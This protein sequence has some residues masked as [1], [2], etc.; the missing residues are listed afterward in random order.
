MYLAIIRK[1]VIDTPADP[2]VDPPVIE[3]SHTELEN[4]YIESASS[5]V[6]KNLGEGLE[7]EYYEIQDDGRDIT[8]EKVTIKTG[9]RASAPD[10]EVVEI[11][12]GGIVV[13]SAVVEA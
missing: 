12:A 7:I 4:V 10:R 13:G 5:Q 6:A 8:L 3:V 2:D 1:T 11:E 9:T